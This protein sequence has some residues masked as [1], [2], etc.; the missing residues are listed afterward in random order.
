MSNPVDATFSLTPA[1]RRRAVIAAILGN[2]LEFFDFAIYGMFAVVIAKVFFPAVNDV[3]S[4][5]ATVAV[6]GAAFVLRPIGGVLL[7]MYTDIAGRKKALSLT[8]LLMALGT[9]MIGLVPP[10]AAIGIAA[11]LLI[12]LAR[13]LQGF[14]MGG[15]FSG[16]VSMLV[17]FAPKHL[18][19]LYGSWQMSSQGLAFSLGSLSAFLLTQ[20]LSPEALESWGWRIP[21]ILGMLIGPVGFYIRQRVGESPE[22]IEALEKQPKQK[23]SP[24]IEV[25]KRFPKEMMCGFGLI[26]V[27]AAAS[28]VVIIYLPIFGVKQLGLTLGEVQLST[29]LACLILLLLCPVAGYWS[30]RVGR[31]PVL[32]TA[33]IAYGLMVYPLF[34]HLLAN[35]SLATMILTQ[36]SLAVSM[37]FFWGPMP[38][39]MAELFPV[40]I[41]STGLSLSFNLGGALFGGLAPLYLT[42]LLKETGNPM[43]PAYYLLMSTV[44][45]LVA[46]WALDFNKARAAQAS[47]QTG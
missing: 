8:V 46:T 42:Y 34:S 43:V 5:M 39:T 18:R 29:F 45:G 35:A 40:R 28:Y 33:I 19:G 6:F 31:K 11:P 7:G 38:A 13:L 44:F 41:R 3:N 37:S 14:S 24:L 16:A 21:F 26:V 10:Y 22:F 47:L 27:G 32:F 2:A 36:C 9:G 15:E 4:I 17:E 25:L 12:V 23:R 20:G 30:D 1:V